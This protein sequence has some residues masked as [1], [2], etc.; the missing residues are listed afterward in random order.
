MLNSIINRNQFCFFKDSAENRTVYTT[1][2]RIAIL[3]GYE[4][5][6]II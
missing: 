2:D 1:S 4:I 6:E 3:I 5:D